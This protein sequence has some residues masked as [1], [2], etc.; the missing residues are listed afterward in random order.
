MSNCEKYANVETGKMLFNEHKLRA[1]TEIAVG[2]GNLNLFYEALIA[3]KLLVN[4]GGE[5]ERFERAVKKFEKNIQA[6]LK[7]Y[8]QDNL[9]AW[10]DPDCETQPKLL[11]CGIEGMQNLAKTTLK[12]LELLE[13][14]IDD[15]LREDEDWKNFGV[16]YPLELMDETRKFILAWISVM[17][18][19][20][21]LKS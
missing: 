15:L 1:F 19:E 16:N 13:R 9:K 2:C 6:R 8:N 11:K 12:K 7:E 18:E 17:A 14:E 20:A 21:G 5:L 10:N 3:E 4:R